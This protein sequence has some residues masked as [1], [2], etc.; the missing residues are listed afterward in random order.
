[1]NTHIHFYLQI[2]DLF[3]A[4]TF[5]NQNGQK[6]A[7]S[8]KT[9]GGPSVFFLDFYINFRARMNKHFQQQLLQCSAFNQ[10]QLKAYT[11]FYCFLK[12]A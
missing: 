3:I 10:Q 6:I 2:N 11:F 1:M 8:G 7:L 9:K 5:L 12:F 4:Y